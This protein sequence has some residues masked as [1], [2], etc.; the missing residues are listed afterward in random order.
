MNASWVA[1]LAR[2]GVW[3]LALAT[4]LSVVSGLRWA[5]IVAALGVAVL[6]DVRDLLRRPARGRSRGSWT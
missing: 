2:I 4:V 1:W 5:W 3:L 6:A